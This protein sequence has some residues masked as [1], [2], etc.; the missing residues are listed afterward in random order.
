MQLQEKVEE[1]WKLEERMDQSSGSC[2]FTISTAHRYK[3]RG[4]RNSPQKIQN[5]FLFGDLALLLWSRAE[6]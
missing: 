1:E 2:T 6:Q 5:Q 4:E 3:C